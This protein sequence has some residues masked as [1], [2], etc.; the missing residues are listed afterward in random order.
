VTRALFDTLLVWQGRVPLNER[1]EA[2]VEVPL[3]DA[4][5][6]FRIVAVAT[7][8]TGFFGSGATTV[9]STQGLMLFS[10]LPPLVREGDRYRPGSPCATPPPKRW[11]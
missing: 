6:A 5:S 10:G 7:G 1:G 8:G 3:N 2:E 9:Q 11:P 4:L